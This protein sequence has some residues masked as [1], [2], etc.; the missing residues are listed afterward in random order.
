MMLP[1]VQHARFYFGHWGAAGMGLRAVSHVFAL[2]GGFE[3]F[4]W[5]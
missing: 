3:V 2:I 4:Q 5:S 1:C